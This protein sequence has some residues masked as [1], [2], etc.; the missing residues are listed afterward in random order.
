MQRKDLICPRVRFRED[1]VA[2]LQKWRE[3]GD[4]L[5][6]CLDTNDEHIYR[7]ALGKALTNILAMKEVVGKYWQTNR[8]DLFPR[9]QTH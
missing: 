9:F 2:Q 1:L 3:D 7:K 8:F 4:K 6:V 5:I